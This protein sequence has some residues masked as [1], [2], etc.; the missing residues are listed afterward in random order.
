MRLHL[1]DRIVI[2]ALRS[3]VLVMV[4]VMTA[5]LVRAQ[6]RGNRAFDV[7]QWEKA[8]DG[9]D[10]R[11]GMSKKREKK[12]KSNGSG[13]E[14]GE[15]ETY[16]EK[17]S[18]A[19]WSPSFSFGPGALSLFK[20]VVL[21]LFVLLLVFLALKLLGMDILS[22]SNKKTK[23]AMTYE[24]PE[25]GTEEEPE[26]SELDK[27]LQKSIREGKYKLAVRIYYL[28][29][30]QQLSEK[31]WIRWKK[32]KTNSHYLHE[33]RDNEHIDGFRKVTRHYE[34]AWYSEVPL[35]EVA[36]QAE[37]GRFEHFLQQLSR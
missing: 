23:P 30:I 15:E 5:P 9:L 35:D 25:Q 18:D 20:I 16:E 31:G 33:M 19:D 1:F 32:D 12:V 17:E 26:M 13:T 22:P 36:F 4:M 6:E 37:K 34:I 2:R 29:I 7:Q 14:R 10:Y 27:W 11:Q 8:R 24:T 28:M 21:L 3:T